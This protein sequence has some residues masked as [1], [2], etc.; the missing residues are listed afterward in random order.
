MKA[1]L[2]KGRQAIER[3]SGGVNPGA[4]V[5]GPTSW[6]TRLTPAPIVERQTASNAV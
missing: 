4:L 5:G 6:K 3:G 2:G 1:E